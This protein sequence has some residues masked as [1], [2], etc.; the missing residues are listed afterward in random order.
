ML[1]KKVIIVD[2]S[3]NQETAMLVSK[4]AGDFSRK[5]IEIEYV[6]GKGKGLAE[7]RNIG[8]AHSTCEIHVSLDDDVV[9]D[10]NYLKEILEFHAQHPDALGVGGYIRSPYYW[11]NPRTN[12]INRTFLFYFYEKDR[13]RVLPTAISYP[14]PLTRTINSQWLPGANS[15]FKREIL[16][17]IRWD[18]NLKKYSLCEDMDISYR[19]QKSRPNSLYLIPQAKLIHNGSQLGR[20]TPEYRVQMEISYHTYFF[21][22]NIKQT[23][24]NIINFVYGILFGRLMINLLGRNGKSTFFTI[25][26]QLN[27]LRHLKE[28]KVGNFSSFECR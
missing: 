2:D 20:I 21:F 8:L 15:C 28:I 19:V 6:R 10:E 27:M 5:N 4:I 26:A 23:P 24:W 12:A 3:K 18:E 11:P 9:L 25:K 13:C 17:T 14:I 1:P 7:A 22:K 16:N